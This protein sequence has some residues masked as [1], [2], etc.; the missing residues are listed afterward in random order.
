MAW[1]EKPGGWLPSK[2]E[3]YCHRVGLHDPWESNNANSFISDCTTVQ[4]HNTN[5]MV[6]QTVKSCWHIRLVSYPGVDTVQCGVSGVPPL[7]AWLSGWGPPAQTGWLGTRSFGRSH[8]LQTS[9]QAGLTKAPLQAAFMC[10]LMRKPPAQ[11]P[12]IKT[13]AN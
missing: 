8:P 3:N 11:Q 1:G 4:Y 5:T 12:A 10:P 2:S 6:P 9:V 13:Q 7:A